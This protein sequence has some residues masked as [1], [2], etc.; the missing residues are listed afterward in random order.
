M[1]KWCILRTSGSR[2]L[3]LASSLNGVGI[4]AWTPIEIR[5]KRIPR[6]KERRPINVAIMPSFVFA[7]D[8]HRKALLALSHSHYSPH[9]QFSV[10][11]IAGDIPMIDESE[12]E[13]LRR[14]EER[15]K[16]AA[17]KGKRYNFQ[18]G[19]RVNVQ[20][21]GFQGLEGLIEESDG[22]F[23][24]VCFGGS[25]KIKVASFLLQRNELRDEQPLVGVAA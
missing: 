22:K 15:A 11:R 7:K 13:N 17:E 5:Q 4:E 6:S 18:V 19:E 14:A 10:F 3:T 1:G 2:T 21:R 8:E 9:P 12:I 25:I 24:L 23:A 20:E 16:R